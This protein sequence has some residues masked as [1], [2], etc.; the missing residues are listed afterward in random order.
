MRITSIELAGSSRTVLRD[1]T[2]GL[3]RAFARIEREGGN[4][5]FI[6]ITF[7]RPNQPEDIHDVLADDEGDQFSAA[8]MLQY[9]LDGYRGTPSEIHD[10]LRVLQLLAD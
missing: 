4:A 1:G 8:E 2:P 5:E 7:L 3:P 10:Y 9:E 6:R